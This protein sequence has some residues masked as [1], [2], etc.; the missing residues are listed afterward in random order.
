MSV[1]KN[2]G[3]MSGYQIMKR[4]ARQIKPVSGYMG[5]CITG[6]ILGQL[7][8]LGTLVAGVGIICSLAGIEMLLNTGQ[9]MIVLFACAV[10]RGPVATWNSILDI[11]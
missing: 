1:E 10:L 2:N 9:W 7:T 11:M 8:I 4:L 6:G 3:K 5:L